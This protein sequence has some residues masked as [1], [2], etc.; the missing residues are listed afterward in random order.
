MDDLT[1]D[2]CLDQRKVAALLIEERTDAS[3]GVV[4]RVLHTFCE[5]LERCRHAILQREADKAAKAE[6]AAKAQEKQRALEAKAA[7]S[8]RAGLVARGKR[9]L[10]GAAGAGALLPSPAAAGGSEAE[11]GGGVLEGGAGVGE[12]G[13]KGSSSGGG[14]WGVRLRGRKGDRERERETVGGKGEERKGAGQEAAT[15]D[16]VLAVLSKHSKVPVS[17]LSACLCHAERLRA[18]AC[19]RDTKH[20]RVCVCACARAYVHTCTQARR[21]WCAC[22]VF[23]VSRL[24]ERVRGVYVPVREDK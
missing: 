7:E 15:V 20:V 8:R 22:V 14:I 10:L 3:P 2:A 18:R 4:F 19:S 9:R 17:C 11:D 6:R 12:K 21:D 24:C 1:L 16:E 13:E 23:C 5:Q